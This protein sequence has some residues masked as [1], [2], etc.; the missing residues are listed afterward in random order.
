MGGQKYFRKSASFYFELLLGQSVFAFKNLM[1]DFLRGDF[2]L[3]VGHIG[4]LEY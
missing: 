3:E 1:M 4:H 2:V